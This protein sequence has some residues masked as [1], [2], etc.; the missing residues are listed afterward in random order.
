MRAHQDFPVSCC[1]SDGLIAPARFAEVLDVTKSEMAAAI[2]LPCLAPHQKSNR[3]IAA[4][5]CV[6]AIEALRILEIA[7]EAE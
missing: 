5:C 1:G 3:I 2:G 7:G 4:D 6:A